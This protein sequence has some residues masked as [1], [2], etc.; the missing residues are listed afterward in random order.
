MSLAQRHAPVTHQVR[1]DQSRRAAHAGSA[2]HQ[3]PPCT[4][5]MDPFGHSLKVGS[6][7]GGGQV[8]DGDAHAL[9]ARVRWTGMAERGV[10]DQCNSFL[11]HQCSIEGSFC[12]AEEEGGCNLGDDH[13]HDL[14]GDA[15]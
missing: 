3:R 11:G 6:E 10:D 12:P 14:S 2:V 4:V 8:G 7:V 1:H 9:H 15:R 5:P 13:D